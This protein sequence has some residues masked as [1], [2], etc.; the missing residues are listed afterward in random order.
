MSYHLTRSKA[1]IPPIIVVPIVTV[2][3][4][5]MQGFLIASGNHIA[6]KVAL[7][8]GPIGNPP[9]MAWQGSWIIGPLLSSSIINMRIRGKW[10]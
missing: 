1:R 2:Y 10:I 9:R 6:P 7:K 5:R 8:K 4:A 3:Y